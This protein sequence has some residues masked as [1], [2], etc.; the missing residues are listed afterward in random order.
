[1]KRTRIFL[2]NIAAS[3]FV[4]LPIAAEA[5]PDVRKLSC[6]KAQAMVRQNGAVVFTTGPHTYSRFVS[7]YRYCDSW[8]RLFTQYAKTKDNP[9]CPV[10]YECKEPLF[11]DRWNRFR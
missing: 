11:N 8:E 9:K 4:L 2:A 10:A 5:R 3:L 1:M 6:A 7:N